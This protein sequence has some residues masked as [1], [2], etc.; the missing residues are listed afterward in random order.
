MKRVR[1]DV[2]MASY[3]EAMKAAWTKDRGYSV[4]EACEIAHQIIDG[5]SPPTRHTEWWED[6]Y[7]RQTEPE[8]AE[9]AQ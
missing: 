5:L 1:M 2:A 8:V 6:Y 3:I 9:V 7:R 4:D